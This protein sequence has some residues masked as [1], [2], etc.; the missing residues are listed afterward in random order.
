MDFERYY[1]D[2]F[3]MLNACCKK[4]ASGKYDKADSERLF[5]LSKKGRYPSILAELAESFGM[6]LVKV[7]AR[8]FER[9]AIIEEL[10]M[11]KSKLENY[12]KQLEKEIEEC[13]P[14]ESRKT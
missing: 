3:E 1:L 9:V 12:S 10:E 11:A 13:C 14:E 8:E 7:E 5:E 2:L 6:M 4:I